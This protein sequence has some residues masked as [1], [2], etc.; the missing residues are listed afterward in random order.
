MSDWEY[1]EAYAEQRKRNQEKRAAN[2][3]RSAEMLT[4][5]GIEFESKNDGA[6]LIVG[7]YDFWPGTGLFVN[8]KTGEKKR[9]V[10]ELIRRI[11][12]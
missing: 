12:S 9:G 4:A 11:N 5:A 10:G 8:R 1:A 7:D 3:Q 6:H 2:R